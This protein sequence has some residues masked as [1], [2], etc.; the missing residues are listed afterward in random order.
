MKIDSIAPFDNE[1]LFQSF[2][3]DYFIIFQV[4]MVFQNGYCL[5]ETFYC[6]NNGSITINWFLLEPH[7]VVLWEREWFSPCRQFQKVYSGCDFF[8]WYTKGEIKKNAWKKIIQHSEVFRGGIIREINED[9]CNNCRFYT[10]SRYLLL[11]TY[12]GLK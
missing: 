2:I 4:L 3:H 6:W 5:L 7:S 11:W 12:G 10:V 9:A 1:P 8:R